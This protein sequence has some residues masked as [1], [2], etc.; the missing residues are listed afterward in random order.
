MENGYGSNKLWSSGNI[1][2][3]EEEPRIY[4]NTASWLEGEIFLRGGTA[5]CYGPV[6]GNDYELW[7]TR[8]GADWAPTGFLPAEV[9]RDFK[10][11]DFRGKTWIMDPVYDDDDVLLKMKVWRAP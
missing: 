5:E 1:Q 11:F 4:T 3:W 10:V 9:A 7:S 6:L 2:D 8:N